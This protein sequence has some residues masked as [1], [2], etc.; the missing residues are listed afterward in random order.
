MYKIKFHVIILSSLIILIGLSS[1]L[2]FLPL[3]GQILSE[4]LTNDEENKD[5]K[6]L[7]RS[8]D[9]AGSDLYAEQINAY[10]A[11]NKSIIQQSLFTN[12]TNIISQFDTNEPAFYK[13][14]FLISVS[15]GI[16]P[17]VFPQVL[18]ENDMIL[19]STPNLNGFTGFL[20][21][22]DSLKKDD[23][24]W[25]AQRALNIIK[26]KFQIDLTLVE[27]NNKNFYP[28]I[29]YYP[30][31]ENYLEG[32]T[33]N[34][35]MDGYWK[36]LDLDRLKN[37]TYY[38]NYHLSSHFLM[39][40]SLDFLEEKKDL[41][42][43]QLNFN[44]EDFGI[45]MLESVNLSQFIELFTGDNASDTSQQQLSLSE[46][47]HYTLIQ[48][49]YEG[50][51]DGITKIENNQ[52]EFNLRDALGY[53][54]DLIEPSE[55][56]YIALMGAFM[57]QITIHVLTPEIIDM[58]PKYFEFSDY[59]IDKMQELTS[60][61][62]VEDFDVDVI[63]NYSLKLMWN[64]ENGM[65]TNFLL[66]VNQED[67][68]DIINAIQLT[69][70]MPFTSIPTGILNPIENLKVKYKTAGSEPNLVVEKILPEMNASYG[71]NREFSFNISI[72]NIG[73]K[74][75][76]GIPT[77][78]LLD[79]IDLKE[80]LGDTLYDDL[81]ESVQKYFDEYDSLEE[82]MNLDEPPRLFYIDTWG[83]GI[84]DNYYPALTPAN[85]YPYS[86]DMDELIDYIQEDNPVLYALLLPLSDTFNNNDSIWNDDNWVIKP[87]ENITFT[88]TNISLADSDYDT[89]SS[90]FEMNFLL[91]D[92]P[93]PSPELVLGTSIQGTNSSMALYTDGMGWNISSEKYHGNHQL[94]AIFVFENT[95]E[96]DLKNNTLDGIQIIINFTNNVNLTDLD[97]S[98]EVFNF[99]EEQFESIP[100]GITSLEDNK[101]L[102]ITFLK[103]REHLKHVINK[104]TPQNN[105]IILKITRTGDVEFNLSIDDI[106]VLFLTSD[107][108][109]Y[110]VSRTRV[111][112]SDNRGYTYFT[113]YSNSLRLSNF[114]MPSIIAIA[115]LSSYNPD[116]KQI[117]EYC[118]T[119]KNIGSKE[120][121]NVS[122]S[123]LIPGIIADSKNFTVQGN[124]LY[125]NITS[126][127]PSEEKIINFT[128][129]TPNTASIKKAKITFYN[130]EL[131]KNINKTS[132]E[133]YSNEV[134]LNAPVDYI[135]KFP[136]V[137]MAEI[138]YNTTT[139][140][141]AINDR[142]VLKINVKNVGQK[143]TN[144][145]ALSMRV[146]DKFEGLYTTSNPL[147]TIE[148]INY[149]KIKSA[150]ITLAKN[151]WK[152][153][154]YPPINFMTGNESR[155]IQIYCSEP[156]ILGKIQF[157]LNKTVDKEQARI[158]DII[159]VIIKIKNTGTIT[160]EEF[161]LSDALSF[162]EDLFTLTEGRLVNN[163]NLSFNP[164]EELTFSYKFRAKTQI[165][166]NL[167]GTRISY[168]YIFKEE[169]ISN[170]VSIKVVNSQQFLWLYI[171][172]PSFIAMG[173]LAFYFRHSLKY[174]MEKY[175]IKRAEETLFKLSSH[176]TILKIEHTLKERLDFLK[177]K[178]EGGAEND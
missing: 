8:S 88:P 102:I 127:A 55:K 26:N 150:K 117:N 126:L 37:Q 111:L 71:I 107:V 93:Y 62:G 33:E 98:F 27:T 3:S 141:P 92:A 9:V 59:L 12:D 5:D 69:G 119:L 177:E 173:I 29:G 77:P 30:D 15:N 174:A 40:N 4:N 122:V 38:K 22:D 149:N 25:R 66:P 137:R 172:L 178:M 36:A 68:T 87:G 17:R 91:H 2:H 32:I 138:F 134:F 170:E 152:G 80:L 120:A 129:Y 163:Y 19:P 7:P 139:S 14:T 171:L 154:Y 6:K 83:T 53:Q 72:K 44:L 82:F 106:D 147:I 108:N 65:C 47:S 51:D 54:G 49:Q 11:G 125:Y 165:T 133:V 131:I 84:I 76:W 146:G 60:L 103:H 101:S 145:P 128:F 112:F 156:I 52:Y 151:T 13:C 130:D 136:Y 157:S 24:E 89:C 160:I 115:N 169:K 56:S 158:N 21:Y 161:S 39:I 78:Y 18:T 43:D 104:D 61:M 10:V 143:G 132:L 105:T 155:T 63:K 167:S 142:F 164:G 46:D 162:R 42:T 67:P 166:M 109:A 75:A 94:E 118:L 110:N 121:K 64:S 140:S 153:Y 1:F 144:I 85:I 45:S 90:F 79:L 57:C 70:I 168:Y 48:I 35:P 34:F 16:Q 114:D 31:W 159:T 74:D 73:D 41:S 113:R 95:T 116:L 58:T 81:W 28:F 99:S 100:S 86:E 135:K 50:L 23:I 96:V 124:Y 20:Y 97:L 176:D 175:E 148:D 123:I